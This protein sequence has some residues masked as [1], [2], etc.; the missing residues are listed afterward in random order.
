M[1]DERH[2]DALESI[3][4]LLTSLAS[5][6]PSNDTME[7]RMIHPL[8]LL[9]GVT[10]SDVN[11]LILAGKIIMRGSDWLRMPEQVARAQQAEFALN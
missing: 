3:Q 4:A 8:N 6:Q 7:D 10:G 11:G 2:F 5:E 1:K 9:K